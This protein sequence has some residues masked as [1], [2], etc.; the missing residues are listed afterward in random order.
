MHINIYCYTTPD[1]HHQSTI[2]LFSS[3]L[4]YYT[5]LLA[6]TDIL[7]EHAASSLRV[8]ANRVMDCLIIV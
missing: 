3:G 4:W 8:E 2:T 5:A 7:E 6:D 1:I